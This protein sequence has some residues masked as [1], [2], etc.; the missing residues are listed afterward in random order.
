M[1]VIIPLFILVLTGMRVAVDFS[2]YHN[3]FQCHLEY[4]GVIGDDAEND[5]TKQLTS[6]VEV[7]LFPD[8]SYVSPLAF[9]SAPVYPLNLPSPPPLVTIPSRAS[10]AC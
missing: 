2:D 4:C 6:A 1:A 9:T 7:P 3:P 8:F 5:K 10:P